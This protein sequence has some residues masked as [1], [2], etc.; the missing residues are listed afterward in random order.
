MDRLGRSAAVAAV[1]LLVMGAASLALPDEPRRTVALQTSSGPSPNPTP[2]VTGE[3]TPEVS[4]EPTPE[5]SPPDD[6]AG[7][8]DD[9]KGPCDEVEHAGDPE[10]AGPQEPEDEAGT[11]IG[12]G[13]HRDAAG[14]DV[15]DDSSGPGSGDD[16][17]G[18]IEGDDDP[19]DDDSGSEDDDRSGN[20]D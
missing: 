3:P 16:D 13:A 20:D 4:G 2:E 1:T 10:C 17:P 18:A 6:R 12:T 5:A 19:D 14:D 15:A 11:D 9:V 8:A 7:R